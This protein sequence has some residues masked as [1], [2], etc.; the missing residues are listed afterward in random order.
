MVINGV[1]HGHPV[2]S[3]RP[4][5]LRQ[6][7]ISHLTPGLFQGNAVLGLIGG[8]IPLFYASWNTQ[9]TG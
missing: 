7:G 8:Y 4:G 9:A 5:Y 6:K 2:S 1:P 3:D